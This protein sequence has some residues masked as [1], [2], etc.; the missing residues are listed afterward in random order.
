MKQILES[1]RRVWATV[2]KLSKGETIGKEL[3]NA[4]LGPFSNSGIEEEKE[5]IVKINRLEVAF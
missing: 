3:I 5:L 1:P 2:L 4:F